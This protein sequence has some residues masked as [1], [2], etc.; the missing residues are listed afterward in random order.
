[1]YILVLN[2]LQ[3]IKKKIVLTTI[4]F[5]YKLAALHRV[6]CCAA[7]LS[8][9]FVTTMPEISHTRMPRTCSSRPSAQS[10]LLSEGNKITVNQYTFYNLKFKTAYF[11]R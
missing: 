4:C 9:K 2:L 10:R 8:Q 5:R 6:N 11:N 1:M 3:H 7:I